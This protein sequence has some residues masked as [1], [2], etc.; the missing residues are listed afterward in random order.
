MRKLTYALCIVVT[1]AATLAS[2]LAGQR[3]FGGGR[4]CSNGGWSRDGY[5]LPGEWSYWGGNPPYDGQ[6][7]WARI[8]YIGGYRCQQEGPGWAH[9]VPRSDLHFMMIM[10]T[11]STL[12]PDTNRTT[13]FRLDDPELMKYPL[14][15]LSEPGG[16]EMS[17]QEEEGLRQY[18]RKGGSVIVDDFPNEAWFPFVALMKHA[19]PKLDLLPLERTHPVFDSFYRLSDVFD[20]I[21]QDMAQGYRGYPQYFGLFEDNDVKK[22]LM[23]IVNF[24]ADLGEWWEFSDTGTNPV[25]INNEAYKLGVNY[26]VYAMTH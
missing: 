14:A 26:L 15:Y 5:W 20:R 1:L 3:N 7:R 18:L 21:N 13:V 9:D 10:N 19:F 24:Q 2:P 22:R 25:D 8:A 17:A 6:F 12:K 16:W 11:L 23:M 4:S